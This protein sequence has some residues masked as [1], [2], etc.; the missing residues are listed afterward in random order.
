M[1]CEVVPNLH[2]AFGQLAEVAHAKGV[3]K[4]LIER[5]CYFTHGSMVFAWFPPKQVDIS[6][7]NIIK[8][9]QTGR[10]EHHYLVQV[11]HHVPP[12]TDQWPG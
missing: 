3:V 6:P 8:H 12:K 7:S 2:V 11:F 10:W 4:R 5:I 1:T 9:Q